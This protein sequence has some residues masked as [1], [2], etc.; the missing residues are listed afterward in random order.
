M[1]SVNC[2]KH[3]LSTPYVS[4]IVVEF[5]EI[6]RMIESMSLLTKIS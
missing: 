3:T 6:G 2:N 1:E 5:T 4:G